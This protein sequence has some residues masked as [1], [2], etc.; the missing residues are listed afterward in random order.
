M[1][2]L[3]A[4]L[5]ACLGASRPSPQHLKLDEELPPPNGAPEHGPFVA[6]LCGIRSPKI[7]TG[8]TL[9]RNACICLTDIYG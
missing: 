8:D 6:L 3:R 7:R 1:P 9:K 5:A 4:P 2:L